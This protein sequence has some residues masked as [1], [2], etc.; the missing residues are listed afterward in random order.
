M[1]AG[2]GDGRLSLVS[3]SGKRPPIASKA[4][5]CD[6][7]SVDGKRFVI[8]LLGSCLALVVGAQLLNQF[9]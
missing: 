5:L 6:H 9:L 2:T 8:L 3:R 7:W 4:P 1:G